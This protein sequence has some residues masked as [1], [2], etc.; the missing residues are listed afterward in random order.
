MSSV[1]RGIRLELSR[2]FSSESSSSLAKTSPNCVA[3]SSPE[4]SPHSPTTPPPEEVSRGVCFRVSRFLK[5]SPRNSSPEKV[6]S[7]PKT[8]TVRIS[9][10]SPLRGSSSDSSS[11]KRSKSSSSNGSISPKGGSTDTS[12]RESSSSE[13]SPRSSLL[14]ISYN[15]INF[16]RRSP[17]RS[18]SSLLEKEKILYSPN[19]TWLYVVKENEKEN[20]KETVRVGITSIGINRFRSQSPPL[21][22]EGVYR[23]DIGY[24]VDRYDPI[25]MLT[26]NYSG[27]NVDIVLY[28]PIAGKILAY[29]DISSLDFSECERLKCWIC[30]IKPDESL[31]L[32][33]FYNFISYVRMCSQLA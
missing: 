9:T 24:F 10:D 2:L 14:R 30:Q 20:E 18:N 13:E 3:P 31:N 29:N 16:S 23:H 28:S 11:S 21:V 15:R 32:C 7:S 8:R 33:H 22:N 27:K 1:P 26:V 17:L 6:P 4:T 19:H 12:P 25:A 5:R